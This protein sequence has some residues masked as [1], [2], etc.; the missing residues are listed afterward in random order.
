MQYLRQ[1]TRCWG[2]REGYEFSL[3]VNPR[4]KCALLCV[5]FVA[6]EKHILHNRS[7][8]AIFGEGI[9][10]HNQII[11]EV[12]LAPDFKPALHNSYLFIRQAVELVDDLV[13]LAVVSSSN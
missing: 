1:I 8:Y 2:S 12:A 10:T 7:S 4:Q 9:V 3:A 5:F 13:Y 11:S 6:A